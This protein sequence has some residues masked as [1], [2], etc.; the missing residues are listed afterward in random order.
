MNLIFA[1]TNKTGGLM[2][3]QNTDYI[4]IFNYKNLNRPLAK[5]QSTINLP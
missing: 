1:F 2:Y 5:E 3:L 4:D